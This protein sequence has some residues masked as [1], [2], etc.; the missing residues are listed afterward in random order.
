MLSRNN[1]THKIDELVAILCNSAG[2]HLVIEDP[3]NVDIYQNLVERRG[4]SGVKIH[5]SEGRENLL[6]VYRRRAEFTHVPVAFVANRNMWLFEGI[7][8]KYSEVI[9]T[10]GFSIE[11]D[12]YTGAKMER[13]LEPH[14]TS[15]H[16]QML[17]FAIMRFAFE[18]EKF[19]SGLSTD[20]LPFEEIVPIDFSEPAEGFYK[21]HKLPS[22]DPT[23]VQYIREEYQLRLR[24]E[25][26]FQIL[27]RFL[28]AHGRTFRFNITAHSLYHIALS[29]PESNIFLDGLIEKVEQ[30]LKE[31][32]QK[33]LSENQSCED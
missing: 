18:V 5:A 28:N 27:V 16:R 21:R 20:D 25:W 12:V 23:L 3:Q 2:S 22:P 31:P 32:K 4:I 8:E 30:K 9:C 24:G 13:L 1:K 33:P 7:P 17:T 6:S 19:H 26:L 10:G 29:M 11:N 15:K 14:E